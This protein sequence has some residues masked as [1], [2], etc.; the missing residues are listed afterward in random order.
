MDSEEFFARLK[1]LK[2]L[3]HLAM[4]ITSEIFFQFQQI[5]QKISIIFHKLSSLNP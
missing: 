2:H 5:Q 1:E 4:K 3:Q